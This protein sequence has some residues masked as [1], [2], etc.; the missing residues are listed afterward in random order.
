SRARGAGVRITREVKKTALPGIG[1]RG[2]WPCKCFQHSDTTTRTRR[3]CGAAAR[4]LFDRTRI[5]VRCPIPA[6]VRGY[7]AKSGL[8]ESP[9]SLSLWGPHHEAPRRPVGNQDRSG[10]RRW[11]WEVHTSPKPKR[12]PTEVSRRAAVRDGSNGTDSAPL[13]SLEQRPSV[14][15]NT[16]SGG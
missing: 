11:V 3:F 6:F 8:P 2:Q 14:S 15:S 5:Q 7:I 10:G 4:N 12:G 16:L 1:G 9:V 13:G